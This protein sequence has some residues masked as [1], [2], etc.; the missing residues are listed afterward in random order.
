M[1]GT[2]N[3]L[4]MLCDLKVLA[5]P[6]DNNGKLSLSLMISPEEVSLGCDDCEIGFNLV[7]IHVSTIGYEIKS[8][9]G[10]PIAENTVKG[11][12]ENQKTIKKERTSASSIAVGLRKAGINAQGG[13]AFGRSKQTT[14]NTRYQYKE[15]KCHLRVR[16]K[17]GNSWDITEPA[18]EYLNA[19][20][21]DDSNPLCEVFEV[22]RS[23][24]FSIDV[25]VTCK[26]RHLVI[27][28]I[29]AEWSR[30]SIFSDKSKNS[31]FKIFVAKTLYEKIDISNQYKG[32]IPLSM[33]SIEK[34]FEV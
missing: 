27:E 17:A 21:L 14:E 30:G 11:V 22:S 18:G 15:E 13:S 33:A 2:Q 8:R 25:Q 16:A 20:Y 31:L 28:K 4:P 1:K 26:Q 7:K 23:N 32:W 29:S 19:T 34:D 3:S 5:E 9:F 10:N 6:A 24:Q 12:A